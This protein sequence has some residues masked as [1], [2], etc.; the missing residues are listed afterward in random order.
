[1]LPKWERDLDTYHR[2]D[3]K[4]RYCGYDFKTSPEAFRRGGL[5]IDHLKPIRHGGT[6]DESNRFT[7]CRACNADKGQM[8]FD[9]GAVD[10]VKLYLRLYWEECWQPAVY[11][12]VKAGAGPGDVKGRLTKTRERF[13]EEREKNRSRLA[14]HEGACAGAASDMPR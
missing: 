13:K 4:C 5:C 2:D 9:V 7:C 3:F 11:A 6:D 14:R 8:D 12:L 10:D 1:M